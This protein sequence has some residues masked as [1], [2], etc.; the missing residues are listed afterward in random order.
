MSWK[1][2]RWMLVGSARTGMVARVPANRTWLR[3]RVARWSS[4]PRKLR[5]GVPLGSCRREALAWAAGERWAGLTGL[6]WAGGCSSVKVSG[7]Q[8]R[9]RCQ[10]S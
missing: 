2:S 3:V 6:S 5:S 10:V 7:A 1:A 8:A 4:R 9:R